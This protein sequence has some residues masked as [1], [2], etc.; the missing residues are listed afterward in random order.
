MLSIFLATRQP[1]INPFKLFVRGEQKISSCQG[2]NASLKL[3][4]WSQKEY[5]LVSLK[6][7]FLIPFLNP[8]HNF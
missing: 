1:N 8:S 3:I 7:D 6:H 4:T 2:A 5:I